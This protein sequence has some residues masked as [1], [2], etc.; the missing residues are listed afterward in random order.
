MS[1]MSLANMDEDAGVMG[2]DPDQPVTA[3]ADEEIVDLVQKW[4]NE[5]RRVV[6]VTAG[7]AGVGKS[8]LINNLLGLKGEEAAKA[9]R[10]AR[11][12]TKNVDYYEEEVHGI[13]VRIIDTPG[14]EAQDLNRKEEQ[15]QL[16]TLSL[17]ADEKVD[18]LLYCISLAGRFQK[19]DQRIVDKLTKAFGG[20]I[21][22]HTI[23]VFTR[24]D[25][26]LTDDEEENRELLEEFTEEFEK[27]LKNV[28]VKDVPVRSSLSTRDVSADLESELVKPEIVGIPVGKYIKTPP[29]WV[30]SLFKEVVKR[31]RM[32]AIPA[33]LVLQGIT[34]RKVAELLSMA[35]S[36]AGGAVGA[37]YGGATGALVLG[38][39]GFFIGGVAG[40]AIAGVAT[41][42][43]GV[44]GGA[45]AGAKVGADAGFGIGAVGGAVVG[46]PPGGIFYGMRSKKAVEEWT[47]LAV[48][49]KA[50]Q[51]VEEL[52]TKK[53]KKKNA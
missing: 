2:D 43:V 39:L 24:G 11:S 44:V 38:S 1:C 21:W 32:N 29:D 35:G 48:I 50:R 37:A 22:R 40:A 33:L 15:E 31:C 16:A 46:V 26:E 52:L 45:I 20:E 28:G 4:G 5:K 25:T 17:L 14:L 23:L 7:R 53:C 10:S 51:N 18:L 9:K 47:G 49:I 6:L 8:T 19:D 41:G 3:T 42:G 36:V 13:T 30:L 34:P 12:V 27:A